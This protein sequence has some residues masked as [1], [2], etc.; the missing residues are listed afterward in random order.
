MSLV[1]C[2]ELTKVPCQRISPLYHRLDFMKALVFFVATERYYRYGL[3]D[4]DFLA[5]FEGVRTVERG[6]DGLARA[7]G[8]GRVVAGIS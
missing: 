6:Y 8:G 1:N 3:E 2:K 7:L 5:A 4:E